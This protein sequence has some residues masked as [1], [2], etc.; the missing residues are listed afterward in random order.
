M[1]LLFTGFALILVLAGCTTQH[2]RCEPEAAPLQVQITL[3]KQDFAYT[4]QIPVTLK[5][6]R[7]SASGRA[8][9]SAG[10]SFYQLCEK[11]DALSC[12]DVPFYWHPMKAEK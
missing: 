12:C 5:V 6:C 4:E 9:H 11:N 8:R 2:T 7:P 1:K 3:P 10:S